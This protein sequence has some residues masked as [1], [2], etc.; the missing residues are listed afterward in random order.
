MA[1]VRS[2]D[3]TEIDYEVQGDGPVLILV[4]GAMCYRDAGP[5]RPIAEQVR[6][7]FSVVL[8]D[9]RGRGSS[10]DTLPF[11]VDREIDDID[12]LIGATADDGP[13]M[14]FGISSGG[15]LAL[16]ATERLGPDRVTRV[17]LY[18]PPFMPEPAVAAA[19]AYTEELSAALDRGHAGEAAALFFRRVGMPAEAVEG[20]RHSPGWPAIE[21]IAP[22]LA[23]DDAA[24]G[25]SRVP[26]A[27][28]ARVGVPVLTLAGG[29][30]PDFLRYGATGVADA[31]PNGRFDIVGG[32]THDI[33]ASAVAPHLKGFFGGDDAS[34]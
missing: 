23:Y 18:E 24:M 32:Q 27:V 1:T 26:T 3:G 14:I 2:A 5:M 29:S 10:G 4:D 13:A 16:R 28:A 15:A 25:D 31:A 12:A 6:D 7:E 19:A 17:A 8:Y 11:D 9:R 22:T 33:Q 34:A 20:M 21:A 30:S